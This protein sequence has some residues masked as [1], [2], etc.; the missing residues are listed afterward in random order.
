VF[1]FHHA[2]LFPYNFNIPAF[3]EKYCLS[4]SPGRGSNHFKRSRQASAAHG[5]DWHSSGTFIFVLKISGC[6][7]P[8]DLDL[9]ISI[10][11]QK[12]MKEYLLRMLYCEMLGHDASFGHIHAVNMTQQ[13]C[14]HACKHCLQYLSCGCAF[15]FSNLFLVVVCDAFLQQHFRALCWKNELAI[16]L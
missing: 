6:D 12:K 14:L 15:S 9:R 4:C 11:L 8:A 16:F 3:L 1:F 10:Y 5:Y 13:V 7:T 2:T